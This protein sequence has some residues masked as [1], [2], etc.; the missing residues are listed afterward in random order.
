MF[1][2]KNQTLK[3]PL[4]TSLSFPENMRSRV[5]SQYTA[6]SESTLAKLRMRGN[7]SNGPNFVKIAGCIIYR[8]SDLDAW[9]EANLVS[10][11]E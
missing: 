9:M 11:D 7:R 8:R 1:N 6:M 2:Q 3:K 10:V 4:E 5:A